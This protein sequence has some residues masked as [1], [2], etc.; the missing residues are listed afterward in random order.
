MR[1]WKNLALIVNYWTLLLAYLEKHM[2]LKQIYKC[3][4]PITT[5]P[6]FMTFTLLLNHD[7]HFTSKGL[8]SQEFFNV[9]PYLRI[10][11][12]RNRPE[13]F[14]THANFKSPENRCKP[15]C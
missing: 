14:K 5:D 3:C 13:V 9:G 2:V 6:N 8:E 11:L 7:M 1:S 15:F 12:W 4:I 10:T